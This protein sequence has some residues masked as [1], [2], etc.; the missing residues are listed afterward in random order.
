MDLYALTDADKKNSPPAD[1]P[2]FA[3][4]PGK[5]IHGNYRDELYFDWHVAARRAP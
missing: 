5:P 3:Q 1:N 4:L 2:W